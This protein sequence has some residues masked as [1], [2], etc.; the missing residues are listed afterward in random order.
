MYTYR[1]VAS[2]ASVGPL[3]LGHESPGKR[4]LSGRTQKWGA[5]NA[6]LLQQ[7]FRGVPNAQRRVNTS[8]FGERNTSGSCGEGDVAA[9]RNVGERSAQ[10]AARAVSP[11]PAGV[12]LH[13]RPPRSR[14]T[15]Q[16]ALASTGIAQEIVIDKAEKESL[17]NISKL[18]KLSELAS[19]HSTP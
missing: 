17:Q 16:P 7:Y 13:W 11:T 6:P 19:I 14:K 9:P 18:T 10:T 12:A 5:S 1:I 2:T 4:E 15:L 8:D 3:Q